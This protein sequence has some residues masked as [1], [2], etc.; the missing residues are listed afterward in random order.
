M[1]SPIAIDREEGRAALKQMI[2]QGKARL[3]AGFFVIV[4]PEGTR[5]APDK[6]A[7]FRIGGAWL[8]AHTGATVLP[9]AHNAGYLWGKHALL[10]R[11]GTITVSIG[12][13]IE[14]RGMKADALNTEVERW[15]RHEQ[16]KMGKP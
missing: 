11:P 8:A 4:F 14:A 7:P 15:I 12:K 3:K 5:I 2:E 10:K 9:V 16:E 6:T 13:P 1:T